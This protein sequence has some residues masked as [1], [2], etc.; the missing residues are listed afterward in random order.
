[1]YMD[2]GLDT[3]DMLIK[4]KL[5][6]GFEETAGELHERLA[7][8]GGE[9]MAETIA[10]LCRNELRSVPQDDR[11]SSY[12]PML[13]KEDGRLDWT[14]TAAAL[15]NQVR[16][17]D[18]WPGAFCHWRGKPLK[19]F[20]TFPEEGTAGDPGRIVSAGAE[21]VKIACGKGI[22]RV[23]QMQLPG[24]KRLPTGEFLKGHRLTADDMLE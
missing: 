22:L 1:M 24:K 12:A 18:P 23:C 14:R 2:A 10:A 20:R 19:L 6:I 13:K 15:H 16:G 8:L 7:V 11:L 4:K 9:A 21:G 3:G 5:S 17:L